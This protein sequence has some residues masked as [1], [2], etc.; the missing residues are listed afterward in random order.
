MAA[1]WQLVGLTELDTAKLLMLF[2]CSLRMK[3]LFVHRNVKLTN[4][5]EQAS[6]IFYW[7]KPFSECFVMSETIRN[8]FSSLFKCILSYIC[9]HGVLP[10][11]IPIKLVMVLLSLPL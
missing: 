3:R 4:S 11:V 10:A 1:A 5:Q 2:I 7:L 9:Q 8:D 6:L